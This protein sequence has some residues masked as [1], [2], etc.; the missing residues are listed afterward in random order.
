LKAEDEDAFVGDA[1]L[2]LECTRYLRTKFPT[3]CIEWYSNMAALAPLVC[4]E[5]LS[6][7]AEFLRTVGSGY[8]SPQ[9]YLFPK[10]MGMY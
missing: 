8:Q 4:N 7:W 1:L 2:T 3:A 9:P 6:K 10:N 5:N